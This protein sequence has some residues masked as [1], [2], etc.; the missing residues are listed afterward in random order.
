MSKRNVTLNNEPVMLLGRSIRE[1]E[2]MPNFTMLNPEMQERNLSLFKERF[3]VITSFLSIDTPVCYKQVAHFNKWAKELSSDVALIGIS[4]DL[5][6]TLARAQEKENFTNMALMSDYLHHSFGINYG[7][8]VKKMHV[9]A[10]TVLILD[11]NNVLRYL[12]VV[13]EITQEPNY[14]DVKETLKTLL[15]SPAEEVL[16]TTVEECA[17]CTGSVKPLSPEEIN[18]RMRNINKWERQDDIKIYR[19]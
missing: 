11:Q 6:F 12:Q 8:L 5:P 10:R 3:K 2:V 7:L 15:E 9:L 16:A 17:P 19:E 1:K 13:P 4:N 14:D 18:A